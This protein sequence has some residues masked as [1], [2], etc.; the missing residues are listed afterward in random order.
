MIS[1]LKA[2][3][4]TTLRDTGFSG[5]FPHFRRRRGEQLDLLTFQFSQWVA[6]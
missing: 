5:S 1:A 4:V 2:I 6:E 3:V